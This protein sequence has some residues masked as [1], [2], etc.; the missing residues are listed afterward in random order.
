MTFPSNHN[1]NGSVKAKII[2]L[3]KLDLSPTFFH[4]FNHYDCFIQKY[5]IIFFKKCNDYMG[6]S[7][8]LSVYYWERFLYLKSNYMINIVRRYDVQK[9][10]NLPNYFSTLFS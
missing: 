6:V 5:Y 10:T 4:R 1:E 8:C 2:I 3:K 9:K 7:I